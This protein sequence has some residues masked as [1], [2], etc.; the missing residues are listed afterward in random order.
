MLSGTSI[1]E[2]PATK[3]FIGIVETNISP[4]IVSIFPST[5][6]STDTIFPSLKFNFF[7]LY[8]FF[9]SAPCSETLFA[10][11]SHKCPGPYLGYQ[12][13]SIKD[14]SVFSLFL[15]PKALWNIS[16]ITAVIEIPFTRCA[17]QSADISLG[18]LPHNFS[19]YFSKNILYKTFPKRFI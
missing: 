11:V 9:I 4:S 1:P 15:L 8:P 19:V 14:V 3:S 17:P 6:H 7:T 2:N 10:N 16:F 5:S 13:S 12:N 18:C